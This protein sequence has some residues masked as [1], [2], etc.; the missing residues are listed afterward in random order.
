MLSIVLHRP[1]IP[2]NTG[3]VIRLCANTGAHLHLIG[4]LGFEL[5]DK[6]LKRA[7]LDYHEYAQ[8][9]VHENLAAFVAAVKPA[10]LFAV[11]TRGSVRYDRIR[12]QDDDAVM[13]GSETSGLP[14]QVIDSI[15]AQQ[16]IR[17]P[18]RPGNRSLNL[19][20][21]V[22]VVAFEAWRQIDYSGGS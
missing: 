11:S 8:L 12:F 18:M 21:A 13:F 6:R 9:D 4:P 19:S 20:N 22:A 16:R 15:P 2:P 1:E 3:N 10:R 17:L 7:G 5:D 14:E